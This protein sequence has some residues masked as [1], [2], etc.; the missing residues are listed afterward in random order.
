MLRYSWTF[1]LPLCVQKKCVVT[2][3]A[4]LIYHMTD[5]HKTHTHL[6]KS[7][8]YCTVPSFYEATVPK[9]SSTAPLWTSRTVT[10][11]QSHLAINIRTCYIIF[12]G[13]WDLC[14]VFTSQCEKRQQ[15]QHS[16]P[17]CARKRTFQASILW[18]N[19][20]VLQHVLLISNTFSTCDGFLSFFFSDG[21]H[22]QRYMY[23][24]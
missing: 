6:H 14:L 17:R 19:C 2:T 12:T 1:F 13:I 21:Y 10:T 8:T 24:K 18:N 15:E 11:Q 16:F 5:V 4:T 7:F 20:T 22:C 23:A 9:F 3:R